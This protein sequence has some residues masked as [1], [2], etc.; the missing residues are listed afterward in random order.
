M[1]MYFSKEEIQMANRDMKKNVHD[2]IYHR[3]ANKNAMQFNFTPFIMAT[4]Q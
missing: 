3:N 4:I 1:N 2:R